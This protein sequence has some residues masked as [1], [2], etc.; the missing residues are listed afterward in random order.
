MDRM[1]ND[2]R[3][4]GGPMFSNQKAGCGICND[5][6]KAELDSLLLE[7]LTKRGLVDKEEMMPRELLGVSDALA[8]VLKEILWPDGK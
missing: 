1:E 2:Y 7:Y 3:K 5:R 8:D 6:Q 4:T